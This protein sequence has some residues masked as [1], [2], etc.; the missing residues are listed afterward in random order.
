MTLP[1]RLPAWTTPEQWMRTAWASERAK[2]VWAPRL[3]AVTRVLGEIEL[4]TALCGQRSAMLFRTPEE[5]PAL[6][7]QAIARN[8]A[9]LVLGLE[10]APRLP[11]QGASTQYR[12]GQ[13]FKFRVVVTRDV[14]Q[15]KAYAAND[16]SAIAQALGYPA[17]CSAFYRQIWVDGG[18][19]DTTLPMYRRSKTMG[20]PHGNIL[21]RWAGV[22]MVRH[23]PCSFDCPH[24][25]IVGRVTEV[26][27]RELGYDAEMDW[28]LEML[29][30]PVEWSSLHGIAEITTPVFKMSTNTDPL[31]SKHVVRRDGDRYP[32]EGAT[33]LVFPF[34]PPTSRAVTDS[35]SFA[36]ATGS[37]EWQQNG[38]TSATGMATAHEIVAD[39]AAAAAPGTVIDLGCGNGALLERI[40]RDRLELQP[41]G[42]DSDRA[43]VLA[44]SRRL[45][46]GIFALG[47]IFETAKWSDRYSL[48]L[49]MPG[50]LA[51]VD[52]LKAHALKSHLRSHAQKVVVYAY[53]DWLSDGGLVGLCGRT[54]LELEPGSLRGG[55]HAQAALLQELR[56][57]L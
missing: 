50:R 33:G 26:T 24:T 15:W 39:I 25:E 36:R 3:S 6:T 7:A 2:A 54:G 51:E 8:C 34:R 43:H 46:H 4:E 20:T 13:A 40:C 11:Y 14:E 1:E 55:E 22:R 5:L 49:L 44:A 16:E 21:L 53:G 9:T 18:W 17:C 19:R 35:R 48:A 38:F 52:D 27:G 41:A 31:A 32:A 47:D 10:G 12:A 28:A 56:A 45:S 57:A 37:D 23:L 30:W 29:A 42:V